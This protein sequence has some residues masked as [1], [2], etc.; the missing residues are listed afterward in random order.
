MI[1]AEN[2]YYVLHYKSNTSNSPLPNISIGSELAGAATSDVKLGF[3][4]HCKLK[5]VIN[6]SI[7][8]GEKREASDQINIKFDHL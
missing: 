8:E 5:I 4:L 7:T 6:P 2:R 3:G 1:K